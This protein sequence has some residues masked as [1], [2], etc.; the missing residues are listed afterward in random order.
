MRTILIL[1]KR[2]IIDHVAY[3]VCAAIASGM[4]IALVASMVLSSNRETGTPLVLA[5]LI[6]LVIFVV[7][8]LSALGVSQTYFDR[9]R[10]IS[11]LL[12]ALPVKRSQIFA[13][14]V[15]AGVLVILTL[16]VPLTVAGRILIDLKVTDLP[17][18]RGL[19]ADLFWGISPACFACYAVGL[20][21]GW[22]TR[23]LATLA[24]LPVTLL[25]PFLIVAKG[26]GLELV[27][28]LLVLCVTCVAGAWCKFSASSL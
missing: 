22:N 11:A 10:R 7:V 6:P 24:I 19:L 14:R 3:L 27:A 16:I 4:I 20:Y 18:Y 2:E 25:V 5:G 9:A 23:S 26:F 28:L 21:A 8:G 12:M 1:L 17:L 13:A 15:L